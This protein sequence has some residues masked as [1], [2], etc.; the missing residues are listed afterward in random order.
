MIDENLKSTDAVV[1]VLDVRAPK[2]SRN[3]FFDRILKDKKKLFILNKADLADDA[4]TDL[5]I[6]EYLKN[7]ETALKTNGNDKSFK[8][9]IINSILRLC[10][11]KIEKNK[12]RGINLP[13]KA[14]VLGIP[15]CGKSTIINL[16]CGGKKAVT[17]NK[18]GVTRG[19]QS[20]RI[21]ND[22]ELIDTP[23]TL[24]AKLDDKETA[25]HLAYIGSI[26]EEILDQEELALSLISELSALYPYMLFN[27]YKTDPNLLP[28]ETFNEICKSKGFAAGG[29]PD[30]SRG[31]VA[32]LDD[33]KKCRIG[34]ISLER[35]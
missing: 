34:K 29:E 13:V 22:L 12:L 35:P 32:I 1:Y 16:L 5:W 8:K 10:A 7:G 23:G 20:V 27:R 17:G 6:A 9:T 18:P 19:K 26:K 33:F 31:A 4:V 24:W 3:P 25:K 14:M 28:I 11:Y 2:S 30:Y 21:D 15:N